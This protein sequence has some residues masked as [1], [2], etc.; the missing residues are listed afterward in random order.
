MCFK[1]AKTLSIELDQS[2][3]LVLVLSH[4]KPFQTSDL[5]TSSKKN[6]SIAQLEVAC[7]FFVK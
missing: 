2:H 5:I 3:M 7:S 6:Q 4:L 1:R